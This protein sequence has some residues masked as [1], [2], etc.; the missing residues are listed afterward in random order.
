MTVQEIFD[1]VKS[2]FGDTSGA[3]IN[4]AELLRWVNDEQLEIVRLT[5]CLEGSTTLSTSQGVSNYAMTNDMIEVRS[6]SV[7]GA[8][9]KRTTKEELDKQYPLR[10]ANY[11]TGVASLFYIHARRIYFY[12]AP[13]TTGSFNVAVPYVKAP[14]L[15][16][17]TADTPEIPSIY[18]VGLVRALVIRAKEKD[19]EYAQAQ[20]LQ[21]NLRTQLSM[22]ASE[23]EWPFSDS[24]PAVRC[25]PGDEGEVSW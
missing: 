19:E 18:H 7:D 23:A 3:E 5:G 22:T 24:Y 16:T 12:P 4:D 10:D 15:L 25:L 2:D 6:I 20:T 14:T 13:S 11:P 21:T 17:S 1:R 8:L 9:I